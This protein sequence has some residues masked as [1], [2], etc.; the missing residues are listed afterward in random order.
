MRTKVDG[1]IEIFIKDHFDARLHNH[2]LH[3]SLH[4]RRSLCVSDDIRIL[5][6]EF[7]GYTVVIFFKVGG[8]SEIY[9]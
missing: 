1:V 4:G 6:Q 7:D 2:P 3:G 8:H 5:F 9:R